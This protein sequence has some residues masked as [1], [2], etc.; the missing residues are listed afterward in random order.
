MAK[1][2]LSAVGGPVSVGII[3]HLQSLGHEVHGMDCRPTAVG[4]HF[5][6]VFHLSPLAAHED[7]YLAFLKELLRDIDVFFPFVDE[8]L[9]TIVRNPGAL[10]SEKSVLAVSPRKTLEI[11]TDKIYFQK[12]MEAAG[13]PIAPRTT[14]VPAIVKPRRG[15]GGV[16]VKIVEDTGELGFFL[17]NENFL[18]QSLLSGPEYTVDVLVDRTGGWINGLARLRLQSKG[19]STVGRIEQA[20]DILSLAQRVVRELPFYGPINIQI[21]RDKDEGRPF[22]V[23]V[24]P[25][26]SGSI[27][28]TVLGGFDLLGAAI[29]LHLNNEYNDAAY[30]HDGLEITRYWSEY[31]EKPK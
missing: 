30:I 22:L 19:V 16:G 23:E 20:E 6:D 28:F 25:R 24:N 15:R 17:E 4:R 1:I 5:V 13:I 9:W 7:A 18:A 8:E 3:R 21:M 12:H 2:L 29:S 31:C 10:T 11:C 14:G 26:L 27:M